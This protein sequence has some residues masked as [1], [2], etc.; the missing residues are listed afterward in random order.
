MR[1]YPMLIKL[2]G[3]PFRC[4]CGGN[5]FYP[6]EG[7][8]VPTWP[9]EVIQCSCCDELYETEKDNVNCEYDSWLNQTG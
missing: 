4:H 7:A 3:K 6:A 9:K 2:D 1:D 5:V 8:W